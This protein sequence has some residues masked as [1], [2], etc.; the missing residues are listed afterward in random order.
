MRARLA[1][2]RRLAYDRPVLA[3]LLAAAL[4]RA[5]A[6]DPAA[7][8]TGDILL[9][10]SRSR[11]GLAIALATGSHYTHVGLV[12]RSGD[13][14]TVIEAV[15]PVRRTPL[16]A[17][18]ARGAGARVTALRHPDLAPERRQALAAAAARYLGR[19]YDLAF[20]AGDDAIY[21]SELVHLAYAALGLSVG[22][23][24]DLGALGLDAAPVRRLL[25]QRWRRHPACRA[26]ASLD[27]CMPALRAAPILT[28]QGLRDDPRLVLVGTSYPAGAR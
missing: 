6:F 16:A 3:A 22:T 4:L 18:L 2:E 26:A 12:E 20:A 11:Q 23:W 5:P 10:T 8:Q 21:C 25:G 7:L 17:F 1:R 27:A 14:L 9:H 28:P 15:Q 13:T 24:T 19:P